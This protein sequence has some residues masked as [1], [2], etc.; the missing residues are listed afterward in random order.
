[1][2]ENQEK[3][4]ALFQST[5]IANIELAQELA[6]AVGEGVWF[7]NWIDYKIEEVKAILEKYC[8]PTFP[9]NIY[10]F[11]IKYLQV[12]LK[13]IYIEPFYEYTEVWTNT[14]TIDNYNILIFRKCGG[15]E[16]FYLQKE[17]EE[18]GIKVTFIGI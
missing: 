1:M 7:S 6:I 3:I 10:F 18:I 12:I 17:L 16:R 13:G 15:F 9:K 2:T 4:L 14:F 11:N 5:D 8:F